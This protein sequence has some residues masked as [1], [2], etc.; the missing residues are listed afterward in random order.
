MS[1]EEKKGRLSEDDVG[2]SEENTSFEDKINATLDKI[3]E[4]DED[5]LDDIIVDEE[6][7][8]IQHSEKDTESEKDNTEDEG[9]AEKTIIWN[10]SSRQDSGDSGEQYGETEE[11]DEISGETEEDVEEE[12]EVPAARNRRKSARPG[13]VIYV[14]MDDLD[15]NA[16]PS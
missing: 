13:P 4:E 1:N 12:E 10:G 11:S 15:E 5:E 6:E 16:V 8:S 7:D 3:L 9:E 14:P 2:T